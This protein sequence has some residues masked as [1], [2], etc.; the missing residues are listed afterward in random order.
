MFSESK[1]DQ[2]EY[3]FMLSKTMCAAA[4]AVTSAAAYEGPSPQELAARIGTYDILPDEGIGLEKTLSRVEDVIL[5]N[6]LRPFSV[7]YAAHL[8]SPAL[9]ESISAELLLSTF[10]QSMDSWD[11]APAATETE[12]ATVRCLCKLFGYGAQAD[13]SFTSGGSQSNLTA[14]LLARDAFCAKRLGRAVKKEGLPPNFEKLRLY[15]S[16]ISHFS[17]QKSAHILGLGYDAVVPVPVTAAQK[18][19]TA[20]L[21]ALI[22]RDVAAGNLPF[23][24][25]ATVGTTDFGSIDDVHALYALSQKYG[26]WLHADAAYGSAL[27]LSQKYKAR[28]G[29]VSLCDSIT[30]DFHKLFLLSISCSCMLVKDGAHFAPLE[31]HADY[32]NRTEDEEDGYTNLVEKSIQTTRRFDAL[33]VWMAF[34]SLGKNGYA[35]IVD[36]AIENA[37]YVYSIFSSQKEFECGPE[38]ELSS[39]VFRLSP[40]FCGT[41]EP[42]RVDRVNKMVRRTLL[43]QKGIVIGQTV[44]KGSTFLKLTLLN[45]R[46]TKENLDELCKTILCVG[47]SARN[48]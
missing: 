25:V 33:K 34:Q 38:P 12:R 3:A 44:Y 39:V 37:H 47:T 19:D 45:P 13:G 35:R 18:M 46:L 4:N 8:H 41:M 11:Q 17:M 42:G 30:V 9:L 1:Q 31:L 28:M 23:C 43:H 10:N 48:A 32:L 27:V 15:T 36:S 6:M 29:D 22:A 7:Q 14:L 20:A 16:E 2:S 5:P 21:E 24:I 26:L 40:F